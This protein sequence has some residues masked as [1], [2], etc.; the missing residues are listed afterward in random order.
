M[1]SNRNGKQKK[2]KLNN[3]GL[4]LVEILVAV[5]I[6]ALVSGPLLHTFVSAAVYNR[7]ARERQRTTTAAQSVMEGFKA[8]DLEELCWQFDEHK[9]AEEQAAHPFRVYSGATGSSGGTYITEVDG[10]RQFVPT[11]DNS[12]EFIMRNIKFEGVPGAAPDVFYDA[13]ISLSPASVAVSVPSVETMNGYLDAVYKQP[14]QQDMQAYSQVVDKVWHALIDEN[15]EDGTPNPYHDFV[16]TYEQGDIDKDKIRLE[17][18]TTV[19][20][21]TSGGISTVTVL[22][23]YHYIVADYPFYPTDE[24][25]P[26]YFTLEGDISIPSVTAYDNT[27]TVANGAL[28]GDV[29][30]YY[31]P[32][33]SNGSAGTRIAHETIEIYN[34][35]GSAKNVYLIKQKNTSLSDTQLNTCENSYTPTVVGVSAVAGDEIYLFHNLNQ[36]VTEAG[37]GTGTFSISGMAETKTDMFAE[38]E[39]ILLYNVKVSIYEA[40]EADSG[41]T[42]TALVDLE[43]T[44]ND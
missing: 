21:N 9:N 41:F 16:Y 37:S 43:G 22:V 34:N 31:Y 42:G 10:V 29:Y 26:D 40:G 36:N 27:D 38:K 5:V 23:N 14:Y 35:S 13:K 39:E 20:I 15:L 25:S 28:L 8:F 18:T 33:Y 11:A 2:R 4:S 44:M 12:Y 30:L 17:K 1:H 3:K 6:L 19:N 24:F 32:A 7:R